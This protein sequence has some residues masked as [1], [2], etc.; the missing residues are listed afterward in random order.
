[1]S[2][3]IPKPEKKNPLGKVIPMQPHWHGRLAARLIH[4]LVRVL[5]VTLRWTWPQNPEALAAVQRGPVIFAI[6][7][8][9][10]ALSLLL[11]RHTVRDLPGRRMAALVS[12]SRDGGL[13]AHVLHLFEVLPVRGS[14]SRR[15]AQALRELILAARSGRDLAVTPDG[16]RGPRYRV[17]EGVILAAQMTGLPIIPVAYRLGW[18]WT[19]GSW[20]RFQVPIP[21]SQ[22]DVVFGSPL[23]VPEEATA[24]DRESMRAELERRLMAITRDESGPRG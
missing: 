19:L 15:G 14:S 6:W 10:L 22:C 9:R 5:G 7:H 4:V 18:K 2:D 16:P 12:A 11:Y 3:P 21:F 20:D 24:E 23:V 1:M 17:Q 8:N 13:L